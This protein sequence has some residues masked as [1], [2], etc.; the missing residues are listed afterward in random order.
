[1]CLE[2]DGQAQEHRHGEGVLLLSLGAVEGRLQLRNPRAPAGRDLIPA[3][4]GNMPPRGFASFAR[5][6][7]EVATREAISSRSHCAMPAIIV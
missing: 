3:R 6:G 1:M 2:R 7:T 4:T 5:I